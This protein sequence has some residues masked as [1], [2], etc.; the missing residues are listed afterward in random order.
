[1]PPNAQP[2]PTKKLRAPPGVTRTVTPKVIC[3]FHAPVTVS[4]SHSQ[5]RTMRIYQERLEEHST[6]RPE[7]GKL[8]SQLPLA[9]FPEA[10]GSVQRLESLPM[11]TTARLIQE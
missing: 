11:K 6:I 1:M 4:R 7:L 8:C 2:H 3:V 5:R 9:N 10:P